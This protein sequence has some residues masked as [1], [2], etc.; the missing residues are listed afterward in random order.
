VVFLKKNLALI[1][2]SLDSGGA[3]RFVSRLSYILRDDYNVKVIVFDETKVNYPCYSPI[4]GLNIRF[5]PKDGVLLRRII[6]LI[7]KIIRLRKVKKNNDFDVSISFGENANMVNYLSSVGEKTII[8]IRG[9]KSIE[10]NKQGLRNKVLTII[11]KKMFKKVDSIICVSNLIKE[12]IIQQD[13]TLKKKVFTL[14]NAYDIN[15]IKQLATEELS[16][17][18]KAVFSNTTTIIS[19]G[20]LK[21]EKG[22]WHLIKAFSLL[23]K[24]FSEIK[25]VI[26]GKHYSPDIEKLESLINKLDLQDSILLGGFKENPYKYISRSEIYVLSSIN[27]GFP[28]ALVEGMACQI[29]VVATDCA[30]GPRE[31]LSDEKDIFKV[32]REIEFSDYGILVPPLNKKE[33]Y[34]LD[35]EECDFKLYQAIKTLLV[36]KDLNNKYSKKSIERAEVFSYEKCRE[37]FIKIVG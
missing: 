28:N 13:L 23:K 22:F 8:S 3:E 21:P 37:E 11:K 16:D 27:E 34:N 17:D 35:I 10:N 36:D 29:P 33:N 7:L 2:A 15:E 5:N 24:E 30:S 31:I 20:T 9:Y 25:L 18:E 19:A 12:K 14:Y 32:A 1:V 4:I 6:N 26:L